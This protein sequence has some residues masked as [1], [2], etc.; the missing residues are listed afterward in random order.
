MEKGGQIWNTFCFVFFFYCGKRG[1]PGGAV[2]KNLPA[3][4]GNARYEG[5]ISELG[6]SPGEGDGKLLQYSCLGNP[7][8]RG[9]EGDR[10]AKRG[11]VCGVTKSGTG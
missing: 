3:S 11:R 7:E 5:S 8:Q 2:T 9:L 4:A 1:F 6:R 10:G